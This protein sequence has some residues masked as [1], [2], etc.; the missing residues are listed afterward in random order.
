M[1][2]INDIYVVYILKKIINNDDI[3][4]KIYNIYIIDK[5][6]NEKLTNKSIKLFKNKYMNDNYY[7]NIIINEDIK[8]YIRDF[9]FTKF[10]LHK[11]YG[12]EKR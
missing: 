11:I 7:T 1:E 12:Y 2:T 10:N 6:Y 8:M 9:L 5:Y 3:I 4:D